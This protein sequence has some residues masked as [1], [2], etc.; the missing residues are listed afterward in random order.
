MSSSTRYD[1]VAMTLHWVM[2]VLI[3]GL[4][5][6][7]LTMTGLKPGSSLQFQ[8]YQGHKSVGITVLAL[9][10]LRL[11][12]RLTHRPPSLP[13][14]MPG[15]ERRL[16]HAGHAALYTLMLAMPLLGW[17]VVSTSPFNIPT[18]LYGVIPFPHLPL[19]HDLNAAAKLL[20]RS[21]GWIMIATVFGHAAAAL[22]HH[23]LLGDAVLTRM[24]PRFGRK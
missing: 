5:A 17:A 7:G 12:W 8:L 22:R 18:V 4:L 19:P 9:A 13:E 23:Y 15:W 11:G 16:A 6:M 24:L 14:T 21:G 2:A 20:H 10:L 1:A 3:L